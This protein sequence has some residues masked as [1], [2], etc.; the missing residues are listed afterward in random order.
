MLQT[1]QGMY[2]SAFPGT[3]TEF[4]NAEESFAEGI[5]LSDTQAP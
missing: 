4:K 2:L 5:N 3:G 1:E